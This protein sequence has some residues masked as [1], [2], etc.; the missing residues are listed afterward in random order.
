MK[1]IRRRTRV[2]GSFPDGRSALMLVAARLRHIA[3]TRWGVRRYMNMDRLKDQENEVM[4]LAGREALLRL[5]ADTE[6]GQIERVPVYKYDR[7]GR[8]LAETSAIIAQ[9]EDSGI[10]VGS[11][12]EGKDALA[13][14]MHLVISEHYSRALAERTRDGLVKRFE[15]KAWTGGPPPYGYRIEK[16]EGGLHRLAVNEE[17]AAVVRW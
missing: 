11:A 7:L 4:A 17:E 12:T 15:Q 2:V 3:G 5:L 6:A 10:E 1:E 8:N 14:G 13:R 16:A 9:L